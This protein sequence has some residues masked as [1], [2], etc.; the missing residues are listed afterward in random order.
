MVI[1]M[2]AIPL[3]GLIIVLYSSPFLTPF[4]KWTKPIVKSFLYALFFGIGIIGGS[5]SD[6]G[7]ALPA[8]VITVAVYD[9]DNLL[10]NSFIPFICWWLIFLVVFYCIELFK[11]Y[12][13]VE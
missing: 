4:G 1:S 13:K 12:R 6:P 11:T 8:P 3:I 7:F 2:V 9:F 10:T 5:N